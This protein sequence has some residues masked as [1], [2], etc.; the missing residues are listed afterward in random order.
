MKTNTTEDRSESLQP[1]LMEQ[2][3]KTV[4]EV[5]RLCHRLGIELGWHYILDITWILQNL[6]CPPGSTIIDAGAGYGA[7]QYVLAAR[8]YNVKSVDFRPRFV[9]LTAAMIF[10]VQRVHKGDF[11]HDYIE[12]LQD[13]MPFKSNFDVISDRI[14]RLQKNDL[15]MLWL[16]I[17]WAVA[18]DGTPHTLSVQVFWRERNALG[19]L[20]PTI[21]A[22]WYSKNQRRKYAS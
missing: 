5:D 6:H 19:N 7:L 12:H 15:R 17:L 9:P 18:R 22:G 20:G 3:P 16:P 13:T 21:P 10:D 4:G 8:G 11:S 14:R 1:S 2:Y